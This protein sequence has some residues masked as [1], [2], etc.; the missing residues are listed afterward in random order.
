MEA[1]IAFASV[2]RCITGAT[3]V[4][5]LQGAC[6]ATN[7]NAG[8]R[9]VCPRRSSVQCFFDSVGDFVPELVELSPTDLQLQESSCGHGSCAENSGSADEFVVPVSGSR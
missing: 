2:D 5:V 8:D 9:S 1:A 7:A 6:A 3:C 4:I